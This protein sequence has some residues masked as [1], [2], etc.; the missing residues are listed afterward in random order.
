[1]S[2]A[3]RG[4]ILLAERRGRAVYGGGHVGC[5]GRMG[6]YNERIGLLVKSMAHFVKLSA[7]WLSTKSLCFLGSL[8]SHMNFLLLFLDLSPLIFCVH[9]ELVS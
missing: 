1:M 3:E 7:S 9:H 8:A 4:V 5:K 2:Q 6:I